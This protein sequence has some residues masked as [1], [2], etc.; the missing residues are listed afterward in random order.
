[1]QA[2]FKQGELRVIATISGDKYL[3]SVFAEGR[4]LLSE[5]ASRFF[6]PQ[7]TK[8]QRVKAKN[9]AYGSMYGMEALKLTQYADVTM[10][11]ARRFQREL[12]NLMPQVVEWQ[13]ATRNH[14][15]AGNDLITAFGRRRRYLLITD[16]NRKD[17]E[18][19]CLAYLPQS[20][21]SDICLAS[22]LSLVESTSTQWLRPRITVHDSILVECHESM[23]E[24]AKGVLTNVLPRVARERFTT[25][26]PFPVDL[27]V[28][29]SWGEVE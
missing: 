11:E 2:D 3:T 26:I 15:L 24:S 27:Q 12:F 22:L 21:L 9:I 17:I 13:Q 10:H 7:F 28:G 1:V 8:E 29:R 14:V 16:E 25:R 20:T 23:V 6:G 19:E 5:I 18:K 4:D